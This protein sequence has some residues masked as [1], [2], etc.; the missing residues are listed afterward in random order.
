MHVA[1]NEININRNTFNT[2]IPQDMVIERGE[3]Q[4]DVNTTVLKELIKRFEPGQ[5]FKSID[6]PCGK[7]LFLKYLKALFPNAELHGADIIQQNLSFGI[8]YYPMDLT[9]EFHLPEE[10][11]FDLV[12]SISG[13][14]MFGNTLNFI[15]N[16]VERIKPGGLFVLTNDNSS[17]IIDRMAFITL[18]RHRQFPLV[19]EDDWGITQNIPIQ[20]L[21]RLLRSNGMEIDK[22][23]YTS[24]YWK[25]MLYLPFV[26]L[27]APLQY[28]HVK[29][30]K[31]KMPK[32]VLK[33]MFGLKQ[34]FYKHYV[35]YARKQ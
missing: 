33:Q 16:C 6:L 27:V 35:I 4:K 14:M 8:K 30:M 2:S 10:E 19:Y 20:E 28:I 18:G 29:T 32:H 22:V 5:N 26:I 23:E 9:R 25:D 24:F 15:R 11:K 17:T 7:G 21:I 3:T 34:F 12:T 31:T 1:E 13:V